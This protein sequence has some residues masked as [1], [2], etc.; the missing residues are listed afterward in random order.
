MQSIATCRTWDLKALNAWDSFVR[1][2]MNTFKLGIRLG[3]EAATCKQ[4]DS[5]HEKENGNEVAHGS[6]GKCPVET[7][8]LA[9]TGKIPSLPD[10]SKVDFNG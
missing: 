6:N 4:N 5:K 10:F 8:D 2:M 7:R 3:A 1:F 9:T